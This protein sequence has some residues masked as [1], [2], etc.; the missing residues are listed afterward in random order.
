VF[1]GV[2]VGCLLLSGVFWGI[3]CACRQ[4]K[5][6][7]LRQKVQKYSL[8]GN[9]D[10]EAANCEYTLILYLVETYVFINVLLPR[11]SQHIADRI[12]D[13]FRCPFRDP[14]QVQWPGQ[15]QVAQFPQSWPWK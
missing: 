11:L 5:K 7:R 9:K 12:R 4:S 8:I 3:A 2:I 15:A 1:V 14:H 6:P 10:E 13:G